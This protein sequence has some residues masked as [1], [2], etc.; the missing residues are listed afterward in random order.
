MQDLSARFC[1]GIIAGAGPD[2]GLAFWRK[3]LDASKRRLG[4]NYRGDLD[5]PRVRVISEPDLGYVMQLDIYREA[6]ISRLREILVELDRTC[7]RIVLTCHA[8]Q[9]V[10]TEAAPE[11]AERKVMSLPALAC[12]HAKRNNWT[13]VGLFGAPS[14]VVERRRSPYS[15]LWDI[16]DVEAP[17]N[18]QDVLSLIA[19]AKRLGP[20]HPDVAKR[21]AELISLYS[22]ESIFMACTDFACVKGGAKSVIDILDLAAQEVLVPEDPAPCATRPN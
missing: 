9:G 22:S 6:I 3:V 21:L 16:V 13:K 2:A 18:P 19:E 14:V 4:P 17:S 11:I 5:A 7:N 15:A 8:L 20:M 10:V 12:D 1:I